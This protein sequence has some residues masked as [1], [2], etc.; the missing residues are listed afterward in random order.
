MKLGYVLLYVKD[1]ESTIQFYE[2]AFG[3]EVTF[4]HES[5]D[6]AELETGETKLGIVSQNLASESVPFQLVTRES[7]AP[8]I[9]IA[10]LS[11]DVAA[12]FQRAVAAGAEP[13]LAPVKKP[14]G[15]TVSYV[16]DFNG[17]LVEICSPMGD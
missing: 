1:V 12:D 17:F 10:F 15:Q 2:K 3:L 8:G 7:S 14:W 5:K 6:Y 4:L 11:N 9:E 13:V 16:R